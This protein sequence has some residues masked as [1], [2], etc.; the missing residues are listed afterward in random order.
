MFNIANHAKC[1]CAE[2]IN[3][4]RILSTIQYNNIGTVYHGSRPSVR[5][6]KSE[7]STG[8]KTR[9]YQIVHTTDSVFLIVELTITRSKMGLETYFFK[10]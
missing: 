6:L 8:S 10:K 2:I 7:T 4:T 3:S 5:D 1:R 9:P